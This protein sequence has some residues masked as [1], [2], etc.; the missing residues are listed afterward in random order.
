MR[1]TLLIIFLSFSGILKAPEAKTIFLRADMPLRD[2]TLLNAI[3]QVESQGNPLAVN[4][5][6]QAYG[7]IQIRQVMIDE[8]NRLGG[9]YTLQDAFDV[10]KSKEIFWK[11]QAHH[12][13][14]GDY[15]KGARI[16]NGRSKSN[17]YWT[18]VEKFLNRYKNQRKP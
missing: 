11:I 3:I 8:V 2:E 15:R 4:F 16:W 5:K 14:T 6:E 12:N 7:I 17:K 1:L 10:E 9:N 13:P 18:K